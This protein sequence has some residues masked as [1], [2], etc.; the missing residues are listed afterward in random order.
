MTI[1]QTK[2][3]RRA[4]LI[5][6]FS[7][8]VFL[9]AYMADNAKKLDQWIPADN[10][11]GAED[12]LIGR[13]ASSSRQQRIEL[14]KAEQARQQEKI[15]ASEKI[16]QERLRT[17]N[18]SFFLNSPFRG[19]L[20]IPESWQGKFR[21]EESGREFDLVYASSSGQT[22]KLLAIFLFND[23]E[24]VKQERQ[25]SYHV[26]ARHPGFIVAYGEFSGMGL[27]KSESEEYQKMKAE[28]ADIKNSFKSQQQ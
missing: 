11:R 14:D 16:L 3:F 9:A 7:M 13:I 26:L 10:G 24:W 20:S 27:P 4:T 12:L 8:A 19:S 2:S 1:W 17:S 28:L 15:R 22:A 21:A 18:I 23:S 5:L 25:G 6:L